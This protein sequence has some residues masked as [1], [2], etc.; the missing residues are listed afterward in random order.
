MWGISFNSLSG[1]AERNECVYKCSFI[2]KHAGLHKGK[3]SE[4]CTGRRFRYVNTIEGTSQT[5]M[6]WPTA[7][8]DSR[9]WATALPYGVLLSAQ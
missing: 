3:H 2:Y 6:V 4:K 5:C 9:S 1:K 7:H 8:R